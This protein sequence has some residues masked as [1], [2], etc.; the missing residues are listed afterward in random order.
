VDGP[1]SSAAP[2]KSTHENRTPPPVRKSDI[3]KAGNASGWGGGGT[4]DTEK[5][6][7]FTYGF[8]VAGT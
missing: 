8:V 5:T 1:G 2:T 7:Y 3:G 4:G 6:I